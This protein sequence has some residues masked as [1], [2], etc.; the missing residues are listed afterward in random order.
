MSDIG[1]LAQLPPRTSVNFIE[2]T[3]DEAENIYKKNQLL[4]NR[5]L[6]EITK[7]L[8]NYNF[9]PYNVKFFSSFLIK[10]FVRIKINIPKIQLITR[11][12]Q[13]TYSKLDSK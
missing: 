5:K 10:N 9:L 1:A 4:F 8:S 12:A 3:L 2:V 11:R 6:N 7:I 13:K